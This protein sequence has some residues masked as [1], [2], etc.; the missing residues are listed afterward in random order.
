MCCKNFENWINKNFMC[1]NIFNR[2]FSIV[3]KHEREVT[4]FP[5][6]FRSLN[7]ICKMLAINIKTSS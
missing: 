6:T 4:I 1:K 3:K 5:E 7:I 2:D